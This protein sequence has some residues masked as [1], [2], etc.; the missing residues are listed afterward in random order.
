MKLEVLR[1]SSQVDCTHG[2]L[3]EVNELGKHFLCYT[4]EDEQRVLKVKGETR[5]PA[6][7]YKIE[8][9]R[10]GGFHAR[11]DKN[12]L[13]YTVVCC[14]SLMFLVLSIFLFI[15]ET[16]TSILLVVLSLETVRK[17]SYSPRWVRW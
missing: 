1:T 2:L 14:M 8:L 6:G 13:V 17:Q 10:E 16:L 9:R 4:L 7:T 3:F 12:I 15:L 11:Y 5:I